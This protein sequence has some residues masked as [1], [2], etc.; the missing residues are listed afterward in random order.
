MKEFTS[1][2]NISETLLSPNGCP[3]DREQ[4]LRTLQPYLLEETHELLEAIDL[5]DGARM[6]EELGDVLYTLIFIAKLAEQGGHFTLVQALR[7]VSEKLIRRHPHV[8]GEERVNSTD[9][10][11]QNW[12]AIKRREGRSDPLGGIPPGLPSLARAQKM[13]TK[14]RRGKQMGDS[15]RIGE[16]AL[17]EA[18]WELVARAESSGVD[19]E[20]ALRRYAEKKRTG[21]GP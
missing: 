8:F 12:E 20:G 14:L 5:E 6:A 15:E 3:W 17:G 1:L 9:D 19:A 7:E 21:G 2:V 11:V 16:E 4:T 18:L 10:V 13:I